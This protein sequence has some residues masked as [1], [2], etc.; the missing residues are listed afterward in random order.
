LTGNC[1]PNLTHIETGDDGDVR[2]WA[3]GEGPLRPG[4]L[5]RPPGDTDRPTL[6]AAATAPASVWVNLLA[7]STRLCLIGGGIT[8][9]VLYE[10][11]E[12]IG[13]AGSVCAGA[14]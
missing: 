10:P 12:P 5:D 8:M 1:R 9:C 2:A 4:R 3:E 14:L 13:A 7:F 6:P 11:G